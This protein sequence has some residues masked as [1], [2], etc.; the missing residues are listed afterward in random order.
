[1]TNLGKIALF[2]AA[3][4]VG[5]A[6]RPVLAQRGEPYR[7]VG[8]DASRLSTFEGAEAISA[9]FLSGEGLDDAASG[10][11]TVIYLAGAPYDHFERH[12]VM[13]RNA[14]EAAKRAGV[15][16]FVHIAPVYSYGPA[17]S[18]PVPESQPHAPVTKK[19]R[20]RLEQEQLVLQGNGDG[21][22]TLILH[23]PDFYGP[24]ADNSFANYF[25]GEAVAGKNATFIGPL[26]VQRDFIYVPDVA[27]PI[28]QLAAFDDVWG[29]Y[30]NLGSTGPLTG[31]ELAKFVFAH[32]GK[33][34]RM[35]SVPKIALQLFG[36]F[37]PIMRELVEM[38]Y[39]YTSP[40]ILDDSQLRAKLGS[41]KKTP[42]A[43]GVSATLDW[44]KAKATS[45]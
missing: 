28:L 13:T 41:L 7:V 43:D 14:L 42:Y 2:G 8:R 32:L 27:E 40:F 5:N 38:Y 25:M 9:D 30:W 33:P 11:D 35:Q 20:Y 34:E 4:A 15:K 1:M 19:G 31:A 39:L 29:R 17:K 26:N 12:P 3:G 37:N 18:N 22:R 44:M 10:V 6:L 36:L 21:L 16:R 24:D 45:G 23:L